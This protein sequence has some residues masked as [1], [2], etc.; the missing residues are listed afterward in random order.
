MPLPPDPGWAQPIRP[1]ACA[2][3]RAQADQ[4]RLFRMKLPSMAR[5]GTLLNMAPRNDG[6][7]RFWLQPRLSC[8]TVRRAA[9]PGRVSGAGLCDT[10]K[11]PTVPPPR[12]TL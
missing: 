5:G 12:R 2:D 10:Q 3:V 4:C 6:L 8:T 9:D 11:P 7:I 1:V